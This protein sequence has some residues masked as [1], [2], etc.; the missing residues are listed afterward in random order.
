MPDLLHPSAEWF[1]LPSDV[2]SVLVDEVSPLADEASP[3]VDKVLS[4]Y[5]FLILSISPCNFL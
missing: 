4:L 3:L 2:A 5:W 1:H